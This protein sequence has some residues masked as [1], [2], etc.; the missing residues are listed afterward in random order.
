MYSSEPVRRRPGAP[1]STT[2]LRDQLDTVRQVVS[3]DDEYVVLPRALIE[4]MSLPWQHQLAYLLAE[5]R[6]SHGHLR[7]PLYRV[8]PSSTERLVDLDDD[9]LTEVGYTL[10]ID[11]TGELVYRSRNGAV[12][13]DPEQ[14]TVLV[15]CADPVAVPPAPGHQSR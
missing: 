4:S 5:L 6:Q 3:T 1:T 9:Q 7:W 11:T 8:T 12:V 14:A 15:A 2:P 13:P 10:E